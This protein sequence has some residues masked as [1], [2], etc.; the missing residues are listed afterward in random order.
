MV[1]LFKKHDVK[2]KGRIF[3]NVDGR[4]IDDEITLILFFRRPRPV[5]KEKGV[6]T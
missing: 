3:K 5:G 6:A 2:I 4:K 1:T